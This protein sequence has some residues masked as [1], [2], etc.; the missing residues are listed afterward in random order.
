MCL[1][2]N[3]KKYKKYKKYKEYTIII[4]VNKI[5]NTI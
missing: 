3:K 5:I 1:I 4:L 2:N